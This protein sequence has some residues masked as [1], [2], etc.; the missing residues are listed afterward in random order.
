MTVNSLFFNF[1][2]CLINLHTVLQS[3]IHVSI[4]SGGSL[5]GYPLRN[6][7]AGNNGDKNTIKYQ[8]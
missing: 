8:K 4:K 6:V 7:L 2:F 5:L 1:C 3:V